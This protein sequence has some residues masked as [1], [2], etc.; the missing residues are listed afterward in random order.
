[1]EQT[2]SGTT[3]EILYGPSGSKL[4]LLS[5]QTISKFFLSLPGGGTAV[6]TSSGLTYYRHPDWLGSSR[7]ASTPSRTLYYDGA[8]AP[9]GES[10]SET[11]TTDRN[12]TGQNQDMASDLYD[13]LDREY[14]P[15]QGRWLQPDPAGL[16]AVDPTN[17]QSWNRYAY[18][19][20]TPLEATDQLGLYFD[21]PGTQT[22]SGGPCTTTITYTIYYPPDGGSPTLLP[23]ISTQCQQP[24]QGPSGPQGLTGTGSK[25]PPSK[26]D[27][28]KQ[29]T[30]TCLNQFY[31]SN[32]GKV[33]QF[34]SLPSLVPGWNPNSG[35]N[36]QSWAEA[37]LG[38][39][40]GT[41]GAGVYTHTEEIQTLNGIRNVASPLES[42]THGILRVFGKAA[43]I[44]LVYGTVLDLLAHSGCDSAARQSVG[45]TTPLPPGWAASF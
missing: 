24:S 31:A 5:G 8:Y 28:V 4:A 29:T 23:N 3:T 37:I 15:T 30:Q 26:N 32:L 42:V 22:F 34:E 7:I 14:H 6:Y 12:F 19:V 9:F 39:G 43:S 10:Y 36:A 20:G 27:Q 17:P 2:I 21:N 1:M 25:S 16:G 41:F 33:I 18:V 45:Q 40:L 13:F 38:K 44:A 35:E 11:G